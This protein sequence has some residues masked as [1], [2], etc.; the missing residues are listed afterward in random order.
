MMPGRSLCRVILQML[1]ARRERDSVVSVAAIDLIALKD[2]ATTYS[3]A[4]SSG[5][6][7]ALAETFAENGRLEGFAVLLGRSE[8]AIVGRAAI[9]ELFESFLPNV[10]FLHQMSQTKISAVTD[11]TAQGETMITEYMRWRGQEI[12]VVMSRYEDEFTKTSEGWR[13]SRRILFSKA[14]M[15]PKGDVTV[16]A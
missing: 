1:E 7:P 14:L 3:F 13:F 15:Q 5:N 12:V 2:L 10:E 9:S 11:E 4:A 8:T 6:I 16:F